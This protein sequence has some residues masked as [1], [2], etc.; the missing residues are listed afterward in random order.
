MNTTT[1]PN[2]LAAYEA[3][4]RAVKVERQAAHRCYLAFGLVGRQEGLPRRKWE[5]AFESLKAARQR[6]L[7][8]GGDPAAI[9]TL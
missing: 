3:V 5:D 7:D 6:Y 4:V 2:V 9:N 1:S 8:L